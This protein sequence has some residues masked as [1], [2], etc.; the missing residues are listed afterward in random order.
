M[1]VMKFG[2]TSVANAD[3]ITELRHIV[4]ERL[5]TTPRIVVVVSALGGL[6]D[7]LIA[8]ARL[9]E[10]SNEQYKAELQ[11][12]YER[13]KTV[14]YRLF[15]P[16]AKAPVIAYLQ[17]KTDNLEK[18]LY[19]VSLI[20]ELS[21]RTLDAVMSYG[22]LMSSFII[23]NYLSQHLPDVQFLDPRTLI[24]TDSDFGNA[25][26]DFKETN[27]RFLKTIAATTAKVYVMGGF[28][29]SDKANVITTLGRG[30]SDYT[31]AIVG[32]ALDAEEVQIWTDVNGVMTADPRKVKKAFTLADMTY[33]EAFEMSYFGA[34][35]I[36]PPTIQPAL[37]KQI[38][39]RILNSFNPTHKGTLISATSADNIHPVKGI[40]S[41]SQIALVTLQ[42]TGMK[43]VMGIAGRLFTALAR[44]RINIILIT[45][46]S[47]EHSIS[48]VILP[49]D[50]DRARTAINAEFE[51]ELNARLIDP[52]II[53]TELSVIAV[54]GSNMRSA[55]GV[56]GRMFNSL[57][58]NGVN[59]RAIAQGSSELN[60]S[61]VVSKQHEIKSLNALHEAFFLSDT[62]TLNVFICGIGLIGKTLL[63][64]INQH[65]TYLLEKQSLEIKV[66]SLSNSRHMLHNEEGIDLDKWEKMLAEKGE[67]ADLKTLV[68]GM[69]DLNLPNSIFVDCTANKPP[70][71]YYETILANSIA[72]VT[73]NKIANS[74]SL[75]N[76]LRYKQLSKRYGKFMYETN[77]G[78]GLPI[79]G[80]LN[81]LLQSGDEVLKI[82]A[83]LSGSLSFIFN[84]FD[85]TQAF[86]QIVRR[87][88]ALGYT[89]PDP[90]DDLSG[91][92]V[93]RKVLILSRET[94]AQIELSDVVV[95]NPL[96]EA[97]KIAPSVEEFFVALEANDSYFAN[98]YE[99]AAAEGKVLRFLAVIEGSRTTVGLRQVPKDSPFATLSGS[100]NMVVFTTN[101]YRERPLVV[102]GPGAGAEVTAAGVFAEI[103]QI[104]N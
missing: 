8:I 80:T 37:E 70:V 71:E 79:I 69:I 102:K 35:V 75:A 9:A 27:H 61:A 46:A 60:I 29:A 48:F 81:N 54:I 50:A 95:E 66:I 85:N 72:V 39:I 31:A 47:S 101:R 42:G 51:T 6:T 77:V 56:S 13:H 73:P 26:V 94:G 12:V 25:K 1:K 99:T 103:I 83:V 90:R 15:T 104:G 92:D 45:Q 30:G 2:G 52:V 24:R 10:A 62:Q 87:A 93:A 7:Q 53:E 3:R 82:E 28:V 57:A 91:L 63:A 49:K 89:E 44:Q 88:K 36:H 18:L 98:L 59:I 21:D 78:A 20:R 22:E 11:T 55:V 40:S 34:K 58:R 65:K 16:E 84:N 4:A 38:P 19:G 100:D 68:Q 76:Y 23:S 33:E 14:I 96:P 32:A 67:K 43:G 17:E 64:Q 97:C 5:Q 41:M 74:G 86:S